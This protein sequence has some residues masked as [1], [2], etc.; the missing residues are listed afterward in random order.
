MHP[1]HLGPRYGEHAERVVVAQILL[2]RERQPAQIAQISKVARLVPDGIQRGLVISVAVLS[3]YRR[4][5]L[6]R[7]IVA[8]SLRALKRAGMTTARLGVDAENPHGALGLYESL[9]FSV[10]ERGRIYRKPL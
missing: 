10:V 6:G 1:G 5:G 9:G 8:E 7:A 3:G 2:R 4:L